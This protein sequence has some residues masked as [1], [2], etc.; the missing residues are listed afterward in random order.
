MRKEMRARL[1]LGLSLGL[2]VVVS[3]NLAPAAD[4]ARFHGP[5]GSG[6][7]LDKQPTPV[8][9]SETQNLKWKAKLPGPGSSSPIVIGRRVVITCWTGYGAEPGSRR[10][11]EGLAAARGLFRPRHGQDPLGPERS[12]RSCPKI[13]TRASSRS[14]ATRRTRQRPTAS[15]SMSSSAR[16]ACWP[17]IWKAR[18]SGRR[19]SAPVRGRTV[20]ARRPARSST[21]TW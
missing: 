21:R 8:T 15:G 20:G 2:A 12:S 6:A 1:T 10:R 17:S 5:D 18:S 4:W 11:A 3:C 13:P 7:S 16:R 19:A 9:W 14:T